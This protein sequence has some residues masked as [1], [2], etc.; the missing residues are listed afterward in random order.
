LTDVSGAVDVPR[1]QFEAASHDASASHVIR[2]KNGTEYVAT[3]FSFTDS[4]LVVAALSPSDYLYKSRRVPII[5][6]RE[7]I[8][9]IA[10]VK[11]SKIVPVVVVLSAAALVIGL[12]YWLGH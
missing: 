2:V 8:V 7:D 3:Q 11:S 1:E 10:P 5:V 6:P 4:T 9:S 12:G